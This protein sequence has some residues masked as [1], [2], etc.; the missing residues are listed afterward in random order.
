MWPIS[1]VGR[2]PAS[3][4]GDRGSIPGRVISKAQKMI[5]DPSLLYTQNYK[6]WNKGKVE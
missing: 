6:V 4:Q 3:G 1:L 2:V 5:L